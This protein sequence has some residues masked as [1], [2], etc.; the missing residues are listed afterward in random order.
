MDALTLYSII[1]YGGGSIAI[2]V[3]IFLIK[4]SEKSKISSIKE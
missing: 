2:L 3:A 1:V 4:R